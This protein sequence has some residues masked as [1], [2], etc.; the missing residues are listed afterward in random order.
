MKGTS[1]FQAAGRVP[2]LPALFHPA[3]LPVQRGEQD[4]LVAEILP[5]DPHSGLALFELTIRSGFERIY[6]AQP[7]GV[8]KHVFLLEGEME[9]FLDG[10]WTRLCAG[11]ALQFAADRPHG[12]RNRSGKPALL[13]DLRQDPACMSETTSRRATP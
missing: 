4:M 9:L 3:A 12:Y 6:P 5:P 1:E 7:A 10:A 8:T 13:H 11:H 2:A